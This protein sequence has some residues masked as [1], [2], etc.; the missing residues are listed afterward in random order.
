MKLIQNHCD[1]VELSHSIAIVIKDSKT[2]TSLTCY[3]PKKR[4]YTTDINSLLLEINEALAKQALPEIN[5]DEI[6]PL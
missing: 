5:M 4:W 1:L 3:I 2:G 6:L